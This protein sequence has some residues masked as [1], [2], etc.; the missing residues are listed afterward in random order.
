MGYY[1]ALLERK[2]QRVAGKQ[3]QFV[4]NSYGEILIP[5]EDYGYL[6]HLKALLP[7]D[8]KSGNFPYSLRILLQLSLCPV[9]LL[10]IIDQGAFR[11]LERSHGSLFAEKWL[12]ETRISGR[13]ILER[14]TSLFHDGKIPVKSRMILGDCEETPVRLSKKFTLCLISRKYGNGED[15]AGA[16][17]SVT[18]RIIKQ[19]DIPVI[20]Y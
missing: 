7:I 9:T 15:Q 2:F 18:S 20:I 4:S 19:I 3:L 12:E 1:N 17:S 13:L 8:S 6:Q 10:F 14:A 16:L 5:G 11:A